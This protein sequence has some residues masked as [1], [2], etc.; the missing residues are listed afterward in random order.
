M[1]TSAAPPMPFLSLVA[2][3]VFR[4]PQVK[5]PVKFQR[6]VKCQRLVQ[7]RCNLGTAI[8]V[9]L[10]QAIHR[11]R[12]GTRIKGIRIQATRLRCP[13]TDFRY[14]RLIRTSLGSMATIPSPR[15]LIRAATPSSSTRR[16]GSNARVRPSHQS[17][18]RSC[19]SRSVA[20]RSNALEC[21]RSSSDLL[22]LQ[23]IEFP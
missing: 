2:R 7:V 18:F 13:E 15:R 20:R 9:K 11:L 21:H 16:D 23:C 22:R 8:L 1:P 5:L 14:R 17:R 6:L 4:L 12:R 3:W 10:I 19:G